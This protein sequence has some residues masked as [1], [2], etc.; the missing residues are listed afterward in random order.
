MSTGLSDSPAFDD[1]TITLAPGEFF[2]AFTDGLVEAPSGSD[3][4]GTERTA[5]VLE[6]C[7]DQSIEAIA[8]AAGHLRLAHSW[9]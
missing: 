8:E 9:R 6:R 7:A 2:C 4:F 5:A 1:Q 3:F